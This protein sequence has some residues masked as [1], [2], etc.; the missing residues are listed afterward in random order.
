MYDINK[1]KRNNARRFLNKLANLLLPMSELSR[2][3]KKSPKK[4]PKKKEPVKPI[5]KQKK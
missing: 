3:P 4:T 5:P 2:M 1:S